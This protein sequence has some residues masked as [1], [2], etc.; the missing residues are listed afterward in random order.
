MK[1]TIL[2]LS[3][4]VLIASG[5]GNATKKQ[6][7]TANNETVDN[8]SQRKIKYYFNNSGTIAV[9]FDD[10]TARTIWDYSGNSDDFDPKNVEI[11][12]TYKEFPTYLLIGDEKWNLYDYSGR[13]I[14]GWQIING[15]KVEAK[16]VGR[17]K[18]PVYFKFL[19]GQYTN[20]EEDGCEFVLDIVKSKKGYSYKLRVNDQEYKGKVTLSE[21]EPYIMLEGIPWVSNLGELKDGRLPEDTK[22]EPTFGIDFEWTNCELTM[23]NYGNSMN[24]YVKFDCGGKYITLVKTQ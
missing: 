5:C 2:M 3:V 9:C 11:D 20:S 21:N 7:E 17:A 12:E 19:E 4:L 1:K 18:D 23:Q 15:R 10:G 6:N 22:G 14:E 16:D 13:T 24:Y 8:Q